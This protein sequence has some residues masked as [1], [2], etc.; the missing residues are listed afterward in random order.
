MHSQLSPAPRHLNHPRVD[1]VEVACLHPL[2]DKPPCGYQPVAIIVSSSR[3]TVSQCN[4][5]PIGPKKKKKKISG[6]MMQR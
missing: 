1:D 5:F 3:F 6:L 2:P 4:T